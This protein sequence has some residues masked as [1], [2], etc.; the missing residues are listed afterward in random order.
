M[1]AIV[2]AGGRG[3]RLGNRLQG[4]PKPMA[5]IGNRPFL[6]VLLT[7]LGA[8]GCSRII[9]SVGYLHEVIQ[10]YFGAGF[11]GMQLE[12]AIEAEPLGTGGG[13]RS[14]MRLA[15]ERNILV[16]NGDT[17]L[18]IDYGKLLKSHIDLDAKLTIAAV[19]QEDVSRFGALVIEEGH[20]VSISEK[21]RGGPGWINGG[22]YVLK[23]DMIWPPELPDRFSFEADFLMNY[24]PTLKPLAFE[25]SGFFLDIGIPADLDRAQHELVC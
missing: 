11:G 20:I 4:I 6:Q 24:V 9:L 10:R 17:F 12:Y 16:L 21:G 14:A 2:L 22:V 7:R 5:P 1:E 3:T 19:K 15:Q 18:Q 23:T 25:C 8:A 13:I